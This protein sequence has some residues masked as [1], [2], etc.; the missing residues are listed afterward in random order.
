MDARRKERRDPQIDDA[1][2][3][4]HNRDES[5]RGNEHSAGTPPEDIVVLIPVFNDWAS[6][7][8]LLPRLDREL[9]RSGLEVDVLVV[10]DGSL[11]DFEGFGQGDSFDAIRRVDVLRLRRNL[12]HQRAI[13]VGL[14]YVEDCLSSSAVVVMDG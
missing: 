12:G 14:A 7:E 10:D 4:P 3:G 6:L 2:A 11:L 5:N 1:F 8:Q 13:A 9:S